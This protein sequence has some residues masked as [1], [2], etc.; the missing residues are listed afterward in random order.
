MA[1]D[2]IKQEIIAGISIG[3]LNGIGP[4]VIIKT[5]VDPAM[6]QICVPVIYGSSKIISFYRKALS[7]PEFNFSTIRNIN[8]INNKKV[9]LLN[10]WDEDVKIEPGTASATAGKYAL[11]SLEAATHDLKEGKIHLLV[12]APVDKHSVNIEMSG[13]TGHT[14]FLAQQFNIPD[15]MMILVSDLFRISFVSGH[16]PL[17]NVASRISTEKIEKCL[18][19]LDHSLKRDFG[20]RKPKIA[21][22]GLNPHAGDNGLLGSEED[23]VIKPAVKKAFDKGIIVYGPYSADG[24]FGA[25]TWRKFDCVLAMY[26]DQGLIPFKALNFE[27]GVNF[28][29][30]LPGIRT[31]PDHGTAYSLAGKNQASESSFRNAVY[32]GCTIFSNRRQYD[33]IN[34]SPLPV[35]SRGADR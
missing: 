12:T 28:T 18:K 23:E 21:V 35:A 32:L 2:E 26:H 9:N 5:F 17:K 10:V 34:A 1:A 14:G 15:P 4:E 29:A 6:M 19:V 3:D 27:S 30:G 20:I 7:L 16:V 11:R 25:A 13:F 31:S 33:M 8:E 22:L 24:F